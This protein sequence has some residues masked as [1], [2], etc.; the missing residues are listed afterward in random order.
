MPGVRHRSYHHRADDGPAW[1]T[2]LITGHLMAPLMLIVFVALRPPGWQMALG[3]TVVFVALSLYLLPRLKGMFVGSAVGQAHARLR[4]RRWPCRPRLSPRAADPRRRERRARAPR[5]GRAAGADGPARRRGGLHAGQV[6]LSRRRGRRRRPGA[7]RRLGPRARDRAPARDGDLAR[8]SPG[9]AARCGPRAMGGDRPSSRP[10]G[11]RRRDAA[12]AAVL[13][14]LFRRGPR[15]AHRRAP[16]LFRAI[17][18]PGRP[19]R[20]D[21]RFFL[22]EADALARGGED[23]AGAGDEPRTCN[24]STC[25][26]PAG[27]RCRSSPRW[28]CRRSPRSW[29]SRG[30]GRSRSSTSRRAACATV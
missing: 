8:S 15:A 14:R 23:F 13:A 16:A 28:C 5:P 27:C 2:I 9:A 12:G 22:A 20:F 4:G 19:R 7:R 10:A 25:P 1:A 17:T 29:P 3:F 26:P 21:A 18:P 24:G 11:A 30:R 6:R